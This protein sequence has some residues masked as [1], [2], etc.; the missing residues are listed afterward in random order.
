M[1]RRTIELRPGRGTAGHV[2][3]RGVCFGA[4]RVLVLG[5]SGLVG[6]HFVALARQRHEVLAPTHAELDVL[7]TSALATYLSR[8]QPEAIVNCVGWADVDGAESQRGDTAGLTHALNANLPGE[9]A[10]SGAYLLHLS[11]D[12]V[13]DGTKQDAPYTE[14]DQPNPLS[15]Y[16]QTKL[17]GEQRVLEATENACIA[18]IEMPF[19][20]RPHAKSD[21]ARSVARRLRAG[22]AIS[23]VV[24]Q[25]ITPVRLE[26]CAVALQ[27]LLQLQVRGLIHVAASSWTTPY[28]YACGIA[29]RL[30]LDTSL[31]RREQFG[32]FAGTRP[33][34]RPQNSWLDVSLFEQR[35]G[36]SVLHSMDDQ[37]DAWAHEVAGTESAIITENRWTYTSSR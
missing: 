22:E 3:Q 5:A 25:R 27:E 37:L 7:D 20:A 26:D 9:L 35:V 6:S 8:A 21:F 18:R 28:D 24:D 12:Y 1:R 4:M 13:F 2:A 34:R 23:G 31:I 36:A 17:A 16:A 30:R 32:V 10:K 33:A 29:R 19:T 14:R 11:T 15:W